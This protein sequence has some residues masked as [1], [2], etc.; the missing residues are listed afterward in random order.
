[1]KVKVSE[2]RG[3][4]LDW[5]VAS[6]LGYTNLRVNP[7]E[8]DNGLIM[9]PP[10]VSYGPVYLCDCPFSSDGGF[11]SPIIEREGISVELTFGSVEGSF[12]TRTG[13]SAW[14]HIKGGVINPP[15]FWGLTHL[16]AAMRCF[17]ASRLGDE[18]EVPEVLA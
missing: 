7:H 3:A 4:T 12:A 18:V 9:D 2:A 13:W 14:R 6:L 8:W 10:R 16:V 5:L 11:G 1:M 15:R 17:V